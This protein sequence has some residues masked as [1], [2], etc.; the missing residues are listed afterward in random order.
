MNDPMTPAVARTLRYAGAA[1]AA[2]GVG[3]AAAA[4]WAPGVLEAAYRA[5]GPQV[6]S[7]IGPA[8]RLGAGIYGG[9][10]A[11]FGVTAYM[12]GRRASTTRAFALGL[13]SWWVVDSAASVAI[14]YPLNALS[15]LGFLAL[16]TPV[17]V[18]ATRRPTPAAA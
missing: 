10:M 5:I 6:H 3:F 17:L 1:T 4:V 8:A 18:A 13:A 2:L 9:L 7:E 16:F 11:G 14:G 15:N 12:V